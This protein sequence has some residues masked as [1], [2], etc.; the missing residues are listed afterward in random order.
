MFTNLVVFGFACV[1]YVLVLGFSLI[2]VV[3]YLRIESFVLLL[4]LVCDCFR[5]W[6]VLV[7]WVVWVGW[8]YC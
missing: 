4:A 3:G 5:S 7:A 1:C 2:C 8:L 6:V